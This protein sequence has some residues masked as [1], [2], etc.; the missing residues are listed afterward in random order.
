MNLIYSDEFVQA[1]LAE[2]LAEVDLATAPAWVPA[3][4]ARGFGRRWRR[5]GEGS[6]T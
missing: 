6:R 3:A 1:R 5:S 4:A 2:R